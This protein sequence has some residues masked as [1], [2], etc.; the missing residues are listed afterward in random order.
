M[1]SL[2][3]RAALSAAGFLLAAL[4]SGCVLWAPSDDVSPLS[5]AVVSDTPAPS[6]AFDEPLPAP[7]SEQ[8][9]SND[10]E[11][12]ICTDGARVQ[13]SYPGRRD[14]LAVSLDGAAPVAMRRADEGGLTAFR[15][16]NLI[17]RRSGV[18]ISLASDASSVTVQSGD[19]LGLIAQ[20]IYGDRARAFEIARINQI[21]NADLIFPGQVLTLASSERRCRRTYL[22]QAS[23]P[24]RSEALT[25]LNRRQFSP[26]SR[27]QPDQTRIRATA[28][29]PPL[30]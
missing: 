2:A 23:Y 27:R 26:P 1:A 12:F 30:H 14:V 9:V 19:T 4:C 18:R 21:E 5:A 16:T 3:K 6:E 29:D 11:D 24:A 13:V 20:R 28:S 7:R 17:L 8:I 10:P 15:S 25:P 22:Q